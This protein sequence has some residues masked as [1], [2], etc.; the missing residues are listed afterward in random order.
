MNLSILEPSQRSFGTSGGG[1]SAAHRFF[2]VPATD[3]DFP[4][5]QLRVDEAIA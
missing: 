5:V 3:F 2:Q 4:I 1:T